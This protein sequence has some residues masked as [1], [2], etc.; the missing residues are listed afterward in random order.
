MLNLLL[1]LATMF[2]APAQD[3]TSAGAALVGALA[4]DLRHTARLPG[5]SI[6]LLVDGE[7]VYA[8]GFGVADL[9]DSTPV[10]TGTQF[11]TASVAKV[12]T[13][14]AAALLVQDGRLDLDAPVQQYV[15]DF[16][17]SGGAITARLLAGHLSG[18]GHYQRSDRI[19]RRFYPTMAEAVGVFAASPRAGPPGAQYHYSSHGFTL[20]SA[21]IEGAT[22]MSFLEYLASAVFA[23]LG[24]TH[25]GPDLRASPP[26]TMAT[27]YG[28]ARGS[29]WR[30]PH[31][32]DPSYKWGAG[33]L[34]S[35]PS[36]LVRLARGYLSGFV[37]SRTARE[38]FTSQRT[39]AGEETG[40]GIA[41][42]VGTD[43]AG[44]RV[45]HH[46]GSMGGARSVLIM[47]PDR[48]MAVAVMTN[49][50][51]P[52]SI[53]RTAQL[54]LEALITA[55]PRE[56][57]PT[58]TM[59]YEGTFDGEPASGTIT[60]RGS[61]GSITMSDPHRTWVNA[62]AVD[63]M[64]LHRVH[65]DLWTLVTPYGL[66]E[67]RLAETEAGLRGRAQVSRTRTWE[68]MAR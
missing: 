11:R 20:L 23:P 17:D 48:G 39:T 52:S 53:E 24:M 45:V 32:E 56:T 22:G 15:P 34:I 61:S 16:P 3:S 14:T 42:R 62:M 58:R 65:G 33:G 51:W 37:A 5:L 30:I 55:A 57:R 6:A 43:F 47:Y 13:A 44:R 10:D 31:P 54:L 7:I 26:P 2:A 29:P 46:A 66:A 60:L 1:T 50:V 68:F 8:R 38:M 19:E 63:S 12:I 36:D 18:L 40:V 9:T 4:E 64:P 25:S 67:L 28:R 49:V 35:T 59:A 21:A 41:W 27:L